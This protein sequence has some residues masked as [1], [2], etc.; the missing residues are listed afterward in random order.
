[1]ASRPRHTP[2]EQMVTGGWTDRR[3]GKVFPTRP[4]LR[5]YQR[6]EATRV[7]SEFARMVAEGT[8]GQEAWERIP[9]ETETQYARFVDYL[10]MAKPDPDTGRTPRRTLAAVARKHGIN[11]RTLDDIAEKYHWVLRAQLFDREF[12]RQLHEEFMEEKRLSVRRQARLGQSM[13]RLAMKAVGVHLAQGALDVSAS[14]AAKLAAVGVQTE[15]LAHDQSTR[16]TAEKQEIRLV[17]EGPAPPW[18]SPGQSLPLP[19]KETP[20]GDQ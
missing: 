6:G 15:R 19:G 16:N 8:L 12:D 20:D 9:G 10:H 2:T 17:W 3:S 7:R 5:A 18:A 11:P 1:M 13:Q 14:D 4:E